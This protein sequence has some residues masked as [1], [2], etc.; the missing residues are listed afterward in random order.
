MKV[1]LLPVVIATCSF[2]SVH[3]AAANTYQS[4]ISANY[5]ETN[6]D[7][8]SAD[9]SNTNLQGAYYFSPVD[10]ANRPLAE[11]AF[12]QK[13]SNVY[14]SGGYSQYKENDSGF[15]SPGEANTYNRSVGVN[16]YIP[17]TIFFLGAGITESK[18]KSDFADNGT[19]YRYT[20]DWDSQWH[21]QAGITP[22]DGLMVWSQFYEDI[23]VSE[24]WNINAKYV[25][26]IGSNG[27]WLNLEA[28]YANADDGY[29]E[30]Q[31]L[32]LAG[33][34]YLDSHLSIGA[35]VTH[36]SYDN[37]G[38]HDNQNEY[39]VRA[40]QYFTDN[41]AVN[42]SYADGDYESNWGIGATLRF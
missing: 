17:D 39:F 11:S 4:E 23:D 34:Y 1:K 26:P 14:V 22:I 5:G 40:N 21:V 25:L 12:L 7:H 33:D 13:A 15:G 31:M 27:Q 42:L 10:T 41:F 35:G 37:N 24:L 32:T 36:N 8:S 19:R 38:Y 20:R 3:F 29:D 2:F 6:L 18:Y 9:I 30:A 28:S 16:F